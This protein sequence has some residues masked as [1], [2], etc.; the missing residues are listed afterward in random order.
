VLVCAHWQ[1]RF[2]PNARGLKSAG[3]IVRFCAAFI[4][5]NLGDFGEKKGRFWGRFGGALSCLQYL[6]KMHKNY[7]KKDLWKKYRTRGAPKLFLF[8]PVRPI[9]KVE[10]KTHLN[11]ACDTRRIIRSWSWRRES[12][13]WLVIRSPV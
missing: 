11:P 8:N 6:Q 2:R 1:F 4:G 9:K 13:F 3:T 5:E 7:Q 12:F 10:S